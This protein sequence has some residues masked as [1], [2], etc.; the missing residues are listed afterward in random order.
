VENGY[1]EDIYYKSRINLI[2]EIINKR[3]N[4]NDK[5]QAIIK[6]QKWPADQPLSGEPW[7]IMI[8]DFKEI[9]LLSLQRFLHVWRVIEYFR[10]LVNGNF[11]FFIRNLSISNGEM[12][13]KAI[14]K[15]YAM[16]LEILCDT[17]NGLNANDK[18]I[19]WFIT[20]LHDIGDVGKHAEHCIIGSDLLKLELSHSDYSQDMIN[21]ADK[22]VKYHIYPGMIAQGEITPRSLIEVINNISDNTSIQD[23]FIKF[24][25]IFHI[26]D[27]A[28]WDPEGNKLTPE[29][30]VERMEYLDKIRLESLSQN[31]WWERLRKL[32]IEDYNYPINIDYIDKIYQQINFLLDKAELALFKKHLNETIQLE[33]CLPIIHALSRYDHSSEKSAKRFVKFF[34]LLSQFA[35][36]SGQSCLIVTSNHY[37]LE[38]DFEYSLK[39]INYNID[40]ISDEMHAKEL[41]EHLNNSRTF[42]YNIP[43]KVETKP[44]YKLI[45]DI[46]EIIHKENLDDFL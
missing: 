1:I 17:Y 8:E 40:R 33:D 11:D 38:K 4:F 10:N 27:F 43:I 20:I 5:R 24:L 39:Y 15:K 19:L 3:N 42:L 31:F 29:N 41:E 44:C 45:I 46:N 18:E 36:I 25:V 22:V 26:V 37:P 35:E 6:L 9:L 7:Q 14:L 30:L 21:L 32:S 23:I 13:T 16:N 12:V 2:T 34:K 28:G